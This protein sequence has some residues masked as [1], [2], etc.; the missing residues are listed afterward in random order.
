ME[1]CVEKPQF[2][3]NDWNDKLEAGCYPYAMDW[4]ERNVYILIGDLIGRP[5]ESYHTDEE[6]IQTLIDELNHFG[7]TVRESSL[8]E[9]KPNHKKIYLMR[10]KFSGRYHL[11]REDD[12]GWSHKYPGKL[13]TNLD[14]W[15]EKVIESPE[16]MLGE[17]YYGWFFLIGKKTGC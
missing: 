16:Q 14:F 17:E 13:P 10:A 8:E 7:Y 6:I 15:K 5:M 3:P 11:F 4:T 12:N 1:K 9:N 2:S